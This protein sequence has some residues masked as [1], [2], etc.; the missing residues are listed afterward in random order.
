MKV[1]NTSKN[2]VTER[3]LDGSSVSVP[4]GGYVDV[5]AEDASLLLKKSAFSA[6]DLSGRDVKESAPVESAKVP[7]VPVFGASVSADESASTLEL[8]APKI[9]KRE[10]TA[11]E[12]AEALA[13]LPRM[14]KQEL[15]DLMRVVTGEVDENATN[16]ELREILKEKL[17]QH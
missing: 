12:K 3:L 17:S 5:S 15:R 11:D 13:A 6:I 7:M 1:K 14:G 10:L 2:P 9:E 8:V 16:K 4:A